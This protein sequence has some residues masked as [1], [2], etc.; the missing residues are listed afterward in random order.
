MG[1]RRWRWL[2]V[3][4]CVGLAGLALCLRGARAARLPDSVVGDVQQL[5]APKAM[6][7]VRSSFSPA[8][9]GSRMRESKEPVGRVLAYARRSDANREALASYLLADLEAL[10]R[11]FTRGTP[12]EESLLTKRAWKWGETPWHGSST[13]AY[14]LLELAKQA[15]SAK[16]TSRALGAI[17]SAHKAL[18]YFAES[19]LRHDHPD[20]ITPGKERE[21]K[22][23]GGVSGLD[24]GELAWCCERFMIDSYL[25]DSYAFHPKA[26]AVVDEYWQ[27]RYHAVLAEHT[28]DVLPIEY[29]PVTMKFAERLAEALVAK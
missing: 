4:A 26:K 15:N 28:G 10:G 27:W 11:R 19:G 22:A 7:A 1:R 5:D 21:L 25:A 6:S 20:L 18:L 13:K 23:R 9:L 8:D 29:E 3:A 24:R 14:L 17:C 2:V 12:I 16:F